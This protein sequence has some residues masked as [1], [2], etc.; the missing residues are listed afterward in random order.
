M[1]SNKTDQ[2]MEQNNKTTTTTSSPISQMESSTNFQDDVRK[3]FTEISTDERAAALGFFADNSIMALFACSLS[4]ISASS[5]NNIVITKTAPLNSSGVD[6]CNSRAEP[7]RTADKLGTGSEC[8]DWEA[9]IALKIIEKTWEEITM[10]GIPNTSRVNKKEFVENSLELDKEKI[11]VIDNVTTNNDVM[12]TKIEGLKNEKKIRKGKTKPDDGNNETSDAYRIPNE[13]NNDPEGAPASDTVNETVK[14]EADTDTDTVDIKSTSETGMEGQVIDVSLGANKLESVS[15]QESAV[16]TLI[17]SAKHGIEADLQFSSKKT[18]RRVAEVIMNNTCCIFPSATKIATTTIGGYTSHDREQK[19]QPFITIYPSYL[20][21]ISGEDLLFAFDEIIAMACA[22]EGYELPSFILPDSTSDSWMELIHSYATDATKK[23]ATT[24]KINTTVDPDS[25]HECLSSTT[26]LSIPLYLLVM[27]HFQLSLVK[28]YSAHKAID[29]SLKSSSSSNNNNIKEIEKRTIMSNESNKLK[30]GNQ[31]N[32]LPLFM[33][34]IRELKKTEPTLVK[35]VLS[36]LSSKF[37][38]IETFGESNTDNKCNLEGYLLLPLTVVAGCLGSR[39]MNNIKDC[40]D[41]LNNIDSSIKESLPNDWLVLKDGQSSKTISNNTQL[42][43]GV[44]DQSII[45]ISTPI[46]G[47]DDSVK[48][49]TKPT[50]NVTSSKKSKKKKKKKKKKMATGSVTTKTKIE[51]KPDTEKKHVETS[52][53]NFVKK[54]DVKK[55]EIEGAEEKKDPLSTVDV[56]MPQLNPATP[57]VSF[58][59]EK[60]TITSFDSFQENTKTEMADKPEVLRGNELHP[61]KRNR[62]V[63]VVLAQPETPKEEV[64]KPKEEVDKPK[65]E[66]RMGYESSHKAD[67]QEDQWETVEARPRGRKRIPEKGGNFNTGNTNGQQN[68]NCKKKASRA[69]KRDRNKFLGRR[70]VKDISGGALDVVGDDQ[71]QR[72]SHFSREKTHTRRNQMT[73]SSTNSK[74]E[75]PAKKSST[76]TLPQNSKIQQKKGGFIRD[77]LVGVKGSSC[78]QHSQKTK[79]AKAAPFSYSERAKSLIKLDSNEPLTNISGRNRFKK[80]ENS[81]QITG[82]KASKSTRTLPADQNTIPTIASTNSAF[83]SSITNVTQRKSGIVRRSDSSTTESIQ[84]P[85]PKDSALDPVKYAS[86]PPP[87]PTLLSPGNNNSTSSSVASS[88]DAPHSGHHGNASR[89]SENDVGCHLLDVCDRLSNEISEFM[90]RR[91]AA[92]A[93]RR[94]ERGLVLIAL[95]KTLGLIWPGMPTV[96]MYG[97]CATNLDLPSSDLDVV[98]CGLDRPLE[99]IPSPINSAT[100][101]SKS[102]G[103]SRMGEDDTQKEVGLPKIGSHQNLSPYGSDQRYSPH[104]MSHHHMQMMYGHMSVNAERVLRLAMELEHQPWAVHVKAIPTASVPV[105]KILADPARLQ[106][107]ITNGNADWLVQQPMKGKSSASVPSRVLADNV[108]THSENQAPMSHY[109]SQQ[110]SPLWRGAD[111]VNGL[112]K[113]DITFEGPEHGGIWSTVFSKQVVQDF[114]NETG[115]SPECTPHVQVLMVLKEL[116]AQRRLNEPFSGGLS[117]YAL[118]LLVI[119]MIGERSII[120]EELE[121]TELQRKVVAAGGGNSVL[122]SPSLDSRE[123]EVT[124]RRKE[125]SEKSQEVTQTKHED[126]GPKYTELASHCK[127]DRIDATLR[128]SLSA[129]STGKSQESSKST[130]WKGKLGKPEQLKTIK[131]AGAVLSPVAT[132]RKASVQSSWASVARKSAST[133]NLPALEGNQGNLE[134]VNLESNKT[135]HNSDAASTIDR[136]VSSKPGSF[137]DAVTKG[138]PVPIVHVASIPKKTTSVSR[139]DEEKKRLEEKQIGTP[140]S[141]R[142]Q[143]SSVKGSAKSNTNEPTKSQLKENVVT[144]EQAKVPNSV[145]SSSPK[146]SKVTSTPMTDTSSF[147]QGF[148]DVIEVLCSGETTPGKLLMHFLLFY[149]QHFE[150]QSTAID[151]SGTHQR[152]A[153]AINGYSIRSSYLQRRNAGSYDP[154]TGM[155]TVDPIVVYDPLEGAEN[156]NV[157]RSCFAWS[158]IRWVFA[159]SYMTLSSAAEMN[160]TTSEGTRNRATSSVGVEGPTYRRDELGHVVVDPSSPLLE[161]LLSF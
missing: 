27:S 71:L 153:V 19:Q 98:V 13:V 101:G 112:L 91:E 156:N 5:T 31:S 135:S 128:N 25:S 116:L 131:K 66:G 124:E 63:S 138:K 140:S 77:V 59:C 136:K 51:E 146:Q 103:E 62:V 123:S 74:S 30:C 39:N 26:S 159:Q 52:V 142:H 88:L 117:S 69:S 2:N 82:T 50:S 84:A 148:H 126:T 29:L 96:E 144:S 89:Q 130:E 145:H 134:K 60:S 8:Y 127:E 86:P 33:N 46:D 157:A 152:E 87:L 14:V 78:K 34:R 68:A 137:A 44:A 129:K 64:D 7:I 11:P 120:R 119:S 95:E 92:L 100:V 37:P 47:D 108:D 67:D 12:T 121:K 139:K 57:N 151:Y 122:R 43:N 94:H 15:R 149:G 42:P 99:V 75:V 18:I 20:N 16:A 22:N 158:S 73:L 56:A 54:S 70:I 61:Y 150:S 58:D 45:D 114:S 104:Q 28:S 76:A 160:A 161:L 147:P 55:V 40:S 21:S 72:R 38:E 118:L 133:P 90:K 10:V 143:F 53:E 35:K 102:V 107:A 113:V 85:K 81:S 6:I 24:K 154:V 109:S 132:S 17:P 4:T 93:I 79:L 41:L 110:S 111:V 141:I 65:N 9:R 125:L 80:N 115:L 1:A 32:W 97:S 48:I 155:L 23:S 105:I 36:K 3:W 106:G 83:T 49:V